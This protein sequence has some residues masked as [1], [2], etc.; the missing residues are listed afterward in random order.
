MREED[1][2]SIATAFRDMNKT[3]A[4]YERYWQENADY[5]I[6]QRLYP[7]LGYVSDGTG[8]HADEWGG[9]L[10]STKNL[11]IEDAEQDND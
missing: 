5:D 9:C 2:S 4:Q 8:V 10:Y 11:I 3:Q 7:K 6:A 1:P